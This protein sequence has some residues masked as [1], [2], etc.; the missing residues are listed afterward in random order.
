MISYKNSLCTFYSIEG[1]FER[2]NITVKVIFIVLYL[3]CLYAPSMKTGGSSQY[4]L[5]A[6]G[7]G[8]LVS[9]GTFLYVATVHVLPE[10]N[11]RGQP[12]STH[13]HI[14]TAT[15]PGQHGG[16]GVIKSL[17]LVTGAGLPVLLA[18]G[19]PDN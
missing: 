8:M 16:M 1:M 5:S 19:L 15:G 6:T 7:V 4:H 11:N 17:A 9:A 14:C 13:N 18:V 10:I 2:A 12:R 3:C